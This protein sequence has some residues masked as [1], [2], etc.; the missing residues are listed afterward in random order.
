MPGT[1]GRFLI[2]DAQSVK[3]GDTARHKGCDAERMLADSACVGQPC[4]QAVKETLGLD[5]QVDNAVR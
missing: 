3:N 5:V 2:V 4:V 1:L